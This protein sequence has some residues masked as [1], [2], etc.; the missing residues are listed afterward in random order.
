MRGVWLGRA[1]AAALAVVR[2]GGCGG[3]GEPELALDAPEQR[4]DAVA[5]VDGVVG[6][7]ID[8]SP[9]AALGDAG[10]PDAASVDARSDASPPDASPPD[11]AAAPDAA[12]VAPIDDGTVANPYGIHFTNVSASQPVIEGGRIHPDPWAFGSGVAV[13]DLD[14]DGD[15]D[16][17]IARADNPG[18]VRPGGPSTILWNDG[19]AGDFVA[20]RPD[21]AVPALTAS[22]TCHGA[23]TVDLEPDGDLDVIYACEGTEI[24]L[25]NDGAGEFVDVSAARGLQGPASNDKS[26]NVIVADVNLDGITDLYVLSFATTYPV[27]PL[28]T[29]H[30]RLYL[31]RGDGRYEEVSVRSN[32]QGQGASHASLIANLDGDRAL[33][34]FV[35]DDR[36]GAAGTGA[37]M[38]VTG[39]QFLDPEQIDAAGVPHY[40]DRGGAHGFNGPWSSMGVALGDLDGDGAEDL[41]TTDI[42]PNHVF[43]VVFGR[44]RARRPKSSR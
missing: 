24:V 11:A 28:P 12:C 23:T 26:S 3:S 33:E 41:Y 8:G 20:L 2:L 29:L 40:V 27:R 15:L 1:A 34:I 32:A 42:G 31:G 10:A 36:F 39:D 37:D 19:R 17:A 43:R 5:Q 9:D 14:A 6:G 13:G 25:E 44:S 22:R 21:T 35:A 18:S 7:G 38:T 16:L 30:N 4:G